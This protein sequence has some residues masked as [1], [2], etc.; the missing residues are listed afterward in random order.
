MSFHQDLDNL[1]RDMH[2]STWMVEYVRKW[3][4]LSWNETTE[5]I[6]QDWKTHHSPAR[7]N[8]KDTRYLVRKHSKLGFLYCEV[9]ERLGVFEG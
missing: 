6:D 5:V 9:D 2:D 1:T 4:I 7:S 3:G 8:R